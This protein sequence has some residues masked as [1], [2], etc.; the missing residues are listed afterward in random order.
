M[1]R[2]ILHVDM[3]EFFAAV[4]KRDNPSLRGQPLLIGG[5]PRGRGVVSTASYEA[6]VFG[7]H[8]AQPMATAVRLCPH[9]IVLPVRG[10]AY[11]AASR[12]VFD[13]LERFTPI[14]EPLSIDEAFLDMTGTDRLFGPPREMAGAIKQAVRE[15]TGLTCSVG[16]APNKFLAKLASDLD[17]PDGLTVITPENVHDV[18]DPLEITTIWG[19]GPSAR[20]RFH[21]FGIRT[22][23]QLRRTDP[24]TLRRFLGDQAL[25]YQKLAGGVDDRPVTPDHQAKSI[26]QEQTFA[27]DIGDPDELRRVML[28]QAEQVARRLR[29]HGM[30]ARTVT[31]KLRTGDFVTLT[32]SQTLRE[33]TD[34]TDAIW[35]ASRSLL[36]QWARTAPEPLR[37]I[38]L[39][40]S[41]LSEPGG[42]QLSL[43]DAPVDERKQRLDRTLD[44]IVERFGQAAVHRAA[45]RPRHRSSQPKE[46]G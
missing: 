44:H 26:S 14:V 21:R 23:G 24:E 37:L 5:D 18:L 25:H 6:R 1:D 19:I 2:R 41:Q 4:E 3:D 43:F 16:A 38:G 36:D 13:I 9:A 17:K 42:G 20:K 33:A 31:V 34:Q 7:C 32:R 12:E 22:V 35:Q 28:G 29:R 27:A 40:V 46:S 8:S 15:G 11:S 45:A 10:K 39:G 30:R